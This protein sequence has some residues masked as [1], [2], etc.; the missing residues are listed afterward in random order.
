[1]GDART[2]YPTVHGSAIIVETSIENPILSFAVFTSPIASAVATVGTSTV[3]KAVFTA[4]GRFTSTSVLLKIPLKRTA[5]RLSDSLV[6]N[7]EASAILSPLTTVT[8]SI[9]L[10]SDASIEP[11]EIGI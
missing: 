11:R 7:C 10:L 5:S 8:M 2:I 6:G 4:R 9:T 1:M 3:E